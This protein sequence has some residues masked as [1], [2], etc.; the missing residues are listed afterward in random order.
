MGV[1]PRDRVN[2]FAYI[3]SFAERRW[4]RRCWD[5]DYLRPTGQKLIIMYSI[6]HPRHH[7]DHW[8]CQRCSGA[9]SS[10]SNTLFSSLYSM[11]VDSRH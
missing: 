7:R 4:Q 6:G 11:D 10:E 9:R 5:D 1:D 2:E 8:H 3:T